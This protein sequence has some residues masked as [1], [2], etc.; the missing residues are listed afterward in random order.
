[1]TTEQ[2]T[3]TEPATQDLAQGSPEAWKMV[4]GGEQ[5]DALDGQT[6]EVVNPATGQVMARVPLGGKADVDRAVTAAREAIDGP[7]STWSASKRGRTLQ[8]YSGLVKQ[9]LEELAQLESRNV[10]KP[11]TSSRGEALAVSLVFEYYAGAANKLFGETIPISRPG[12]DFTLREPIG[13]VGLI[14]PWNFPMNMASWKLGPALAAGNTCVLKPA[15][16]TPLSAIKLGELALEAGFPPGVVNVVTGPGGSAGAALA[17]HPEVGKIAF[18]G[19]TTTGQ[20]I[21]RLAANN[22]KKISLELGGKSPNLVFADADLER[23]ATESPYAVFDNAGQDCCARSRILVERS[24][25]E[26]VVQLFA[27][28]TRK[29]KVGDPLDESTEVG[30]LVSQKQ[31]ER[32]LDYIGI[33]QEE[34]AELV[35]GGSAP[36]NQALAD[37]AYVMPTVFDRCRPEMRIAREEVFGPVVAIIP[38][39]TEEEAIRLANATPY[40]LSGSIWSRDIARA[41]RVAKGVRSGVLSI[42]TNAS[43]HTEAPFG[44]Y[45]MSGMGRELGMHALELYTEVKN[46]F[47]D[48]S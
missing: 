37:G 20:E 47:V 10:G 17:A 45:K 9:H 3:T 22:V 12:L 26:K 38:F 19:E 4:I 11:I 41:I 35:V 8:K 42:N 27:E 28:A 21:M 25:H 34:G 23:F 31:R 46:V 2:R 36:D 48:L 43:V 44:G 24:V 5:V 39:D 14:V 1:M 33:G 6:F 18:T 30:P 13:V 40:G 32:V 16:Y 15:S 7:W 29:V